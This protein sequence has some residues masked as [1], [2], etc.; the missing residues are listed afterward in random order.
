MRESFLETD[1][2]ARLPGAAIRRS[3]LDEVSV[4]RK[5]VEERYDRILAEHG[6]SARRIAASYEADAAERE[7]LVQEICLALW[8][9]LPTFRDECS[10]RTFLFR[11]A[12]NRGVT[13]RHR[14]PPSSVELEK[15]GDLAAPGAHPEGA[16]SASQTRARLASAIRELPLLLRQTIT[17]SLEGLSHREI[18][19]VL[20]I[21]ETNVAVRLNRARAALKESMSAGREVS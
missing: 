19:D 3:T 7:D 13:H 12:H 17:L 11:I 2:T 10:E 15:A 20:G 6:A 18:S 14:R 4:T 8:K 1:L 9:A 5:A 21:S 16:A